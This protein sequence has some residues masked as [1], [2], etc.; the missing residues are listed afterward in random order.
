MDLQHS[1]YETSVYLIITA[2]TVLLFSLGHYYIE[3][4]YHFTFRIE[5]FSYMIYWTKSALLGE[6]DTQFI[7]YKGKEH[8]YQGSRCFV[9]LIKLFSFSE[10]NCINM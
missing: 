2:V 6:S 10:M 7:Y 4:R 1:S 3:V 9:V 5:G 8:V